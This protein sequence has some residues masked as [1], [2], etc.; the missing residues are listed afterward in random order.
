MIGAAFLNT[1]VV[2]TLLRINAINHN[3][4]KEQTQTSMT[5]SAQGRLLPKGKG[6]HT[7]RIKNPK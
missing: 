2:W 4:I 7:I 6:S 5:A 1:S 3:N